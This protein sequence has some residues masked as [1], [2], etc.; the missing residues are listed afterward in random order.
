[1]TI[2]IGSY[3]DQGS[4]FDSLVSHKALWYALLIPN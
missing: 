3:A 4:F 2:P 1:M